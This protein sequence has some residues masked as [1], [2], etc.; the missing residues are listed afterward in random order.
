MLKYFSQYL[1]KFFTSK[2]LFENYSNTKGFVVENFQLFSKDNCCILEMFFFFRKTHFLKQD[3]LTK[4]TT[5]SNIINKMHG[6]NDIKLN[7]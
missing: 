3:I 6:N 1:T 7:T 2:F 5:Q 4:H